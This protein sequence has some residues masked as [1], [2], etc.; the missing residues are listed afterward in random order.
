MATVRRWRAQL[1]SW[2]RINKLFAAV[3]IALC[4]LA[5]YQWSSILQLRKA[6]KAPLASVIQSTV[7]DPQ[8]PLADRPSGVFDKPVVEEATERLRSDNQA[9]R[10]RISELEARL[11]AFEPFMPGKEAPAAAYFGP[12]RWVSVEP[13]GLAQVVV[14]GSG[15]D[16]TVQVLGHGP[17][18]GNELTA[19]PEL[20]LSKIHLDQWRDS[21][22]RGLAVWS[23]LD[24][25][26]LLL[27]TFERQG[28]R[29]DWLT[30]PKPGSN[31]SCALKVTQLKRAGDTP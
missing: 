11:A 28:L 29:V 21:Y 27:L 15:E 31:F 2:V 16:L 8:E 17:P 14:A 12:G 10:T 7:G 13:R 6:R 23:G 3:V 30:V 24:V 20:P 25:T 1:R 22:R 19:W 4:C 9:L 26:D 18:P 5:F